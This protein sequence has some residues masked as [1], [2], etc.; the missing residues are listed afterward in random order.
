MP[1]DQGMFIY[2]WVDTNM[3]N[4]GHSPFELFIV[5]YDTPL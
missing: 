4:S 3:N 2:R 5:E 1:H